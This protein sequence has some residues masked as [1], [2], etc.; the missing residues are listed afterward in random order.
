MKIFVA[1][2][3]RGRL[4][5]K[6]DLVIIKVADVKEKER[7]AKTET[8]LPPATAPFLAWPPL[9]LHPWA[10]ALLPGAWCPSAAAIRSAFPGLVSCICF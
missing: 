2:L 4:F 5:L 10:P 8:V 9:L 3:E 6:G 1:S 7:G